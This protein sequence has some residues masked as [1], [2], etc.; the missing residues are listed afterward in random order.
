M[1]P[2]HAAWECAFV[3]TT[4]FVDRLT[5]EQ[6]VT[7]YLATLQPERADLECIALA[8]RLIEART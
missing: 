8:C 4:E 3:L 1:N 2:H 7:A 5:P 6:F